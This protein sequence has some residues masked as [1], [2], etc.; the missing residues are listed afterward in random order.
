MWLNLLAQPTAC[1]AGQA[2][3]CY[4][5]G[6][7]P[8]DISRRW[9]EQGWFRQIK[10]YRLHRHCKGW[11]TTSWWRYPTGRWPAPPRELIVRVQREVTSGN[12][13]PYCIATS[14]QLAMSLLCNPT[15]TQIALFHL[16]ITRELSNTE[17]R[18]IQAELIILY[19]VLETEEPFHPELTP[20]DLRIAQML[21]EGIGQN[22][23]AAQ[24]GQSESTIRSR[25][26]VMCRRHGVPNR[27]M[28]LARLLKTIQNKKPGSKRSIPHQ[29]SRSE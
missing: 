5:L 6:R 11:R 12:P 29:L 14:S 21:V 18:D 9:R 4:A 3:K 15:P 27:R 24:I 23:I 7:S 20:T 13:H 2:L 28:L 10:V 1:G 22:E 26:A 8:S 17:L 25:I 19:S 16:E